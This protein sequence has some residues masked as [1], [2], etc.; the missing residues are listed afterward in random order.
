MM[1]FQEPWMA[2]GRG[3]Y[4]YSYGGNITKAGVNDTLALIYTGYVIYLWFVEGMWMW[5]VISNAVCLLLP[6]RAE[7]GGMLLYTEIL[8]TSQQ[9]IGKNMQRNSILFGMISLH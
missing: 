6:T 8:Q 5:A 2:Y 4:F 9:V 7:V 1:K 3:V